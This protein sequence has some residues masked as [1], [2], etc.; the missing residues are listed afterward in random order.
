MEFTL[1]AALGAWLGRDLGPTIVVAV[2]LF[3]GYAINLSVGVMACLARAVGKP[4]LESRVGLITMTVN[5]VLT[6]PFAKVAGMYGVIAATAVG[7]IVA[8]AYLPG[9]LK[10][11]LGAPLREGVGYFRFKPMFI[12]TASVL[13][14]HTLLT[15]A[16]GAGMLAASLMVLLAFI[17]MA[18]WL[19]VTREE[20]EKSD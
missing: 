17:G 11:S 12:V 6:Y 4:E 13:I 18:A 16:L 8:T 5:L 1:L 19:F 9:A 7:H 2:V 14:G 3:F 15:F 10:R 20:Y